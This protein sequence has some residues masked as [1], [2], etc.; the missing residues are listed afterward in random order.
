M[1]NFIVK[2]RPL[3]YNNRKGKMQYGKDLVNAFKS[4]NP[5]AKIIKS[6]AYAIIYY[7]YNKYEKI[8]TD[9]LSKPIWDHLNGVVY[10]DDEQIKIRIA[11]SFNLKKEDIHFINFTGLSGSIIAN[12]LA[13]FDDEDHILYIEIGKKSDTMFK[14]NIE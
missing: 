12:L 11:G 13:A 8:D 9:N 3:S 1:Y 4:Q 14:F 6:D 10:N 7:F 5:T 2:R